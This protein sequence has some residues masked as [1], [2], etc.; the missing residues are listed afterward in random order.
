MRRLKHV[1]AVRRELRK[2]GFT[3]TERKLFLAAW[4]KPVPALTVREVCL[5]DRH[6]GQVSS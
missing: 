2:A 6:Y 1:L 3:R 4:G 5:L